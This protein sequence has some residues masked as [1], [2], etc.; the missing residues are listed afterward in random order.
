MTIYLLDENV[1]RELRPGG[2]A[3]VQTWYTTVSTDALLI[4][5]MTF[6]EKRRGA[7]RLHKTHPT[8]ANRLLADIDALEAAYGDGSLAPK[9]K[10]NGTAHWPPPRGF[11]A[12]FWS[13]ATSPT[14][15]DVTST[16]LTHSSQPPR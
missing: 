16:F 3:D 1:L 10:T 15:P 9:T 2:N 13:L 4:S 8:R 5:A 6:F 7:Q 11:R 12:S 14:S